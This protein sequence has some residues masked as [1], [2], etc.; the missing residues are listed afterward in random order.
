MHSSNSLD[1]S[2]ELSIIVPVYNVEKYIAD[3]LES[4]I[5]QKIENIEILLINDGSTDSSKEICENFCYMNQNIYLYN[6]INQGVS[7]ARNKGI[8]LARGRYV[9]FLDSDDWLIKDIL[10]EFI[11][12]LDEAETDLIVSKHDIYFERVSKYKK[13]TEDFSTVCGKNNPIEILQTLNVQTPF[14]ITVTSVCIKRE[15]ILNNKLYFKTGIRHEDE[16]WIHQV[17]LAT[18][19][20]RMFEKSLFCYRFKREGSFN[21]LN[22]IQR[23]FDRIIVIDELNKIEKGLENET[24]SL[25]LRER[26]AVLIWT[27]IRALDDYK[28][29]IR[30]RELLEKLKCR[31]IYLKFG[32]HIR[33]YRI[34]KLIGIKGIC[35]LADLFTFII[36]T[37]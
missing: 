22:D 35:R 6:Q 33:K 1:H 24:A 9:I 32:R 10:S 30:F 7:A 37:E 5:S 8:E 21:E 11:K 36:P 3:C 16:L 28:N 18:Q 12:C 14:W 27:I 26:K 25:L 15:V 31:V 4:I 17:F 19:S 20:V 34:C 23:E 2:I 13:S 29:D